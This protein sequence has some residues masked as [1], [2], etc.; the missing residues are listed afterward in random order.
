MA[1]LWLMPPRWS[2]ASAPA[3]PL[4]RTVS[5]ALASRAATAQSRAAAA[6]TAHAT[7]PVVACARLVTSTLSAQHSAT[8]TAQSLGRSCLPPTLQ[9]TG[10][11]STA[12]I[13]A[14]LTRLQAACSTQVCCMV[15]AQQMDSDLRWPI[16]RA[17]L[18]RR[19][20]SGSLAHSVMLPARIAAHTARAS[21]MQMGMLPASAAPLTPTLIPR[22]VV[23]L[24]GLAFRMYDVACLH[25]RHLRLL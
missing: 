13:W 8:A 24:P 20:D 1:V 9:P 16:A 5:V 25:R 6:R 21:P 2:M 19:D 10:M 14:A 7:H 4:W 17:P 22:C 23:S 15:S 18:R 12:P 11:R 3:T